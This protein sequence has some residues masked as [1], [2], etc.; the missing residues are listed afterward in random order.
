V[1]AKLAPTDPKTISFQWTLAML[2]GELGEA[3]T[4]L[5]RAQQANLS[6]EA[7]ETM[8]KAMSAELTFPRRLQRNWH[9]LLVAAGGL[10]V[11]GVSLSVRR[12][13]KA[14]VPSPE[15]S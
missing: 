11:V 1:L 4:L 6:P 12:R 9:V 14:A 15:A 2:R 13:S 3:K 5:T 8:Q 10:M 7:I